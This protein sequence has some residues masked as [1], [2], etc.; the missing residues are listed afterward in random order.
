[1][2]GDGL[3]VV[4]QGAVAQILNREG[5]VRELGNCV[6]QLLGGQVQA[7]AQR[8]ETHQLAFRALD[9]TVVVGREYFEFF[10]VEITVFIN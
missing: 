9:S 6:F 4:G 3:V 8:E 5:N 1:V 10:V 2:Y 7:A